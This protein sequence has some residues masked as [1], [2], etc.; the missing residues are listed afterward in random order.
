MLDEGLKTIS[1]SEKNSAV[2]RR[3]CAI[4]MEDVIERVK[5]SEELEPNRALAFG[6]FSVQ[7]FM[8]DIYGFVKRVRI[9][10]MLNEDGLP[11]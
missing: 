8:P 10:V 4:S 6:C 3:L 11:H 9:L 1:R 2:F 5:F 7:L